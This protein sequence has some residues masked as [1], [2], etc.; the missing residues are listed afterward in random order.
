[1]KFV[2]LIMDVDN[3]KVIESRSAGL[4]SRQTNRVNGQ[5]TTV[6]HSSKDMFNRDLGSLLS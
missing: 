6:I 2:V 5:T 1:M 3:V 4:V